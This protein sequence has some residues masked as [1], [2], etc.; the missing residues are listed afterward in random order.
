MFG[1]RNIENWNL[2]VTLMKHLVSRCR[3]SKK[4]KKLLFYSILLFIFLYVFSIPA[5][6]N[7]SRLNLISYFFMGGLGAATITFEF[8]FKKLFF[9]KLF[10]F[11][12]IFVVWSLIGTIIYSKNFEFWKSLLLLCITMFI[13]IYASMFY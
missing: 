3:E 4:I 8:L 7:R 12:P 11:I 6:S 13:F 9:S 5:F 1:M 10:L 2:L